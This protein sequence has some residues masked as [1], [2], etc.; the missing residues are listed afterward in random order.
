MPHDVGGAPAPHPDPLP[1]VK[2][3]GE[4]ENGSPPPEG[5]RQSNLLVQPDLS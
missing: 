5:V 4:R 3:E 2:N 1:L